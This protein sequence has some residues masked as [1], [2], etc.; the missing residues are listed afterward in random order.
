MNIKKDIKFDKR[1]C[2]YDDDYEGKLS[3]KFY[4]FVTDNVVLKPNYKILDAGCGTGT[5]LRRLNDKCAVDSYGI[6]V[7]ENMLKEA[8]EKC[9][10]MSIQ[11]CS[12]D[13]T[14]FEDNTFDVITACMAYH[15]FP[16]KQ[17]FV[18]EA[19]R[20]LKS[21]GTLYIADPKFPLPIRKV[22]NTALNVHNIVGEFHNAQEIAELTAPYG[23]YQT[24][25][26]SDAYA[27]IVILT[28]K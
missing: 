27:Q 20:I 28:K 6:D 23:F 2:K 21:G 19:A 13:N 16:D 12:C 26:K 17:G 3:E 10:G 18:K 1:A 22:I 11:L 8:R 7:E 24:G 14:P 9:P 25:Y 4:C 15:H 5:I